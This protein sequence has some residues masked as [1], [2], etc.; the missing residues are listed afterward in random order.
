MTEEE[1]GKAASLLGTGS[2]RRDRLLHS[3][4]LQDSWTERQRAL[5]EKMWREHQ[6][7]RKE[8]TCNRS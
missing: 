4:L 1:V 6:A 2:W 5:V 7:R 8:H 3:L